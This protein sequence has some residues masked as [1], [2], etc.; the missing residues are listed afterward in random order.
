MEKTK[1]EIL[2]KIEQ[3]ESQI[4]QVSNQIEGDRQEN[5]DDSPV[6]Q[7]LLDKKDFLERTLFSLRSSLD[8][9][10]EAHTEKYFKVNINGNTRELWIVHPTQTDSQLGRISIDS[11]MAQALSGN[12]VGDQVELETPAGKQL[13]Q[14]LE[15]NYN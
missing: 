13:I 5:D 4:K 7:E 1:K 14:I 3:L 9:N 11:P 10:L 15:V 6:L 2:L 8:D 12:G